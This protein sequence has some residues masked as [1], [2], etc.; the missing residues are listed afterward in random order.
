MFGYV[1][2]DKQQSNSTTTGSLT[3]GKLTTKV[4]N[5]EMINYSLPGGSQIVSTI[6]Y[7]PTEFSNFTTPVT[8]GIDT[9][10]YFNVSPGLPNST[11][12]NNSTR[13]TLPDNA[14]VIGA[15]LTN[16]GTPIVTTAPIFYG[17]FPVS[18]STTLPPPGQLS[19]ILSDFT[20]SKINNIGGIS[21]GFNS[22]G[23]SNFAAL[24]SAGAV[25]PT[26]SEVIPPT[27]PLSIALQ[28]A[29]LT[30]PTQPSV[31]SGDLALMLTYLI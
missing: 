13:F 4:A 14:L 8:P 2:K 29:S 28:L 9:L 10:L 20:M 5:L 11:K 18:Y 21:A 25:L 27:K 24:G 3:G 26:L 17:I 30:P 6:M 1:P 19:A 7:A 22:A 31:T 23:Y 12:E 16:N 15:L